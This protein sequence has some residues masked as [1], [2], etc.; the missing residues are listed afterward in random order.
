LLEKTIERLITLG[1]TD[2]ELIN[3]FEASLSLF[4]Q[5]FKGLFGFGFKQLLMIKFSG[6]IQYFLRNGVLRQRLNGSG[7]VSAGLLL[8]QFTAGVGGN[9]R[10]S[11]SRC[12]FLNG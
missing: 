10:Y 8:G 3:G 4:G 2:F 11:W 12:A 6:S 5:I 1:K 7:R 9:L